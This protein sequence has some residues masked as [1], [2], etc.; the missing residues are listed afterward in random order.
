M[1]ADFM[2][3]KATFLLYPSRKDVWRNGALYARKTVCRLANLIASFEPAYFGTDR[4]IVEKLLPAV[5]V[6]DM[7]YNDVWIRD[8]GIIPVANGFVGFS[9]NAWGGAEGL[10]DDWS[11]DEKVPEQMEKILRLPIAR[12]GLT[13]EGGN[14]T[15]DG[16][17]TLIA[18]RST[19][20]NQNRN[21]GKS[22]KE[23]EEELKNS[24]GLQKIIWL[25]RGLEFDETG[26]HVDNLCAF[27]GRAKVLLAWTDDA[28]NPQYRVVRSAY[29]IL[30]RESDA[31]GRKLE[32]VKIPLPT[33][34]YRSEA[35]CKGLV[36]TDKSK[37]RLIGEPVQA[38]YIN[39]IFVNGGVIVPQFGD[40]RDG[41]VINI[42]Q[43]LFNGKKVVP[44]Y[45]REI[46]LGG[47]G[48][49]CITKNV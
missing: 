21:P 42:F 5:K 45:A 25:D 3:H 27:I 33:V 32:I 1:K 28:S 20:I 19:I 46:V 6:V 41:E 14:L 26:G 31:H 12:S 9:F 11:L 18:I 15:S 17:G 38:S 35:D 30:T 22:D 37:Q 4:K 43:S 23:I 29:D 48:I 24:L 39:F 2:E 7:Q 34:F 49:H 13:L 40:E 10:Y 36:L 8:N 47:G 16:E 44:F